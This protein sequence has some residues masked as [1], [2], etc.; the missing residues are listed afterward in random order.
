MKA[1]KLN[2]KIVNTRTNA[3]E[4]LKQKIEAIIAARNK[5]RDDLEIDRDKRRAVL[6][7]F[8]DRADQAFFEVGFQ[9][10]S[11]LEG[12]SWSPGPDL[13]D[14]IDKLHPVTTRFRKRIKAALEKVEV[15]GDPDTQEIYD[16]MHALTWT[17]QETSFKLGILAGARLAGY[18][19]EKVRKIAEYLVDNLR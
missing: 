4:E 9:F 12:Q 6:H 3:Q 11:G 2:L 17:D 16:E 14:F 18:S 7:E 1:K 13:S 8:L 15:S 5:E 10:A 19:P